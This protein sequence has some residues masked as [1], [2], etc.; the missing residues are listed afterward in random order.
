MLEGPDQQ[1]VDSHGRQVDSDGA[2]RV[3]TVYTSS[4][5]R[6]DEHLR[7]AGGHRIMDFEYAA[8]DDAGFVGLL[9]G[10]R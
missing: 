10:D 9:P 3:C 2:E 1:S 5:W 4:G 6:A 8:S 7:V